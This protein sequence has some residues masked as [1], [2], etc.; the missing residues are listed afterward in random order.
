M[1]NDVSR[2]LSRYWGW[3]SLLG[4]SLLVGWALSVDL[5]GGNVHVGD[6]NE[7]HWY[8]FSS[9][10]EL[11][12]FYL[13]AQLCLPRCDPM[14]CSPPGPPSM[15]L[16]WQEYWCGLVF[17]PSW[18]LPNPGIKPMSP[19]LAGGFFTTKPPGKPCVYFISSVLQLYL[20]SSV[21]LFRIVNLHS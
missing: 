3:L 2:P 1:G 14:D 17:P 9:P 7:L 4:F 13:R 6:G 19:T 11:W 16:S 20:F 5:L 12:C 15:G 10:Y 21:S 8:V 18:D